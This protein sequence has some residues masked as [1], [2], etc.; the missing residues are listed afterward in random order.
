VFLKVVN[1][2]N[3]L[4]VA[5]NAI[6]CHNRLAIPGASLQDSDMVDSFPVSVM[7]L[8]HLPIRREARR[9]TQFVY[10]KPQP[11]E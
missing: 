5:L 7:H 3:S 11:K 2:G 8:E 4:T 6:D 10:F 1:K 9:E